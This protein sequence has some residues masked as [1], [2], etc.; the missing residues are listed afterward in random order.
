[1]IRTTNNSGA[2]ELA[3][4]GVLVG[5]CFRVIDC[6]TQV[7]RTFGKRK[8]MGWI[9][10]E[11]PT[12]Q[13]EA[14]AGEAEPFFVGKR[15]NLSHNEKAILRIDLQSWFGRRFDDAQLDAAGGFDLEKLIGR[16]A[17][18]NIVHSEDGRYA[19]IM[20]VMPIP[21]GMDCPPAILAPITFGFEPYVPAIFEQLSSGMQEF[22]KGSEE[23][24]EVVNGHAPRAAVQQS[25]AAARPAGALGGARAA[26]PPA[27]AAGR[28]ALPPAEPP[29]EDNPIGQ[30][31]QPRRVPPAQTGGKFDDMDDDIPF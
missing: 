17:L 11:L 28:P 26:P 31:A 29:W 22:I 14:R 21:P 9:F 1:M 8:R 6:G 23:W 16:P 3:P 12:T 27:V 13:R 7:D 2:F 20:G 15:Y 5:R 10:W 24:Q 19:N 4:A 30:P 18:L 25:G